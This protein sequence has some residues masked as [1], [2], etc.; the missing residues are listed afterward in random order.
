MKSKKRRAALKSRRHGF[1]RRSP[2]GTPP[3]TLVSEP[4]APPTVITWTVY[5]AESCSERRVSGLEELSPLSE[6]SGTTWIDVDGTGDAT[7]LEQ[8][9]RTLGL[10]P[11]ALE[12]VVHSHQRAKVEEYGDWLF[13]VARL[14]HLNGELETEQISMFLRRGVLVTFQPRTGDAFAPVRK[15]LRDAAS[16]LRSAGADY[17]AY[18]LLDLTVDAYYPVLENFGDRIDMIDEQ[19]ATSNP[20]SVLHAIHDLRRELLF[21]RRAVWPHRDAL[22]MLARQDRFLVHE[23]RLHL[24]DCVD[25]IT[26]IMEL[27]ETYREM[28]A[29]LRDYCMSL[30]GNRMN[31]VMK[32]LTLTATLF[33]PLSFIT[34]VY[35][36]NF[37]P[38]AS[39]WNMPELRWTFGYPF[40]WSLM[41]LVASTMIYTFYRRGWIGRRE[42]AFEPSVATGSAG[43]SAGSATSATPERAAGE[44]NATRRHDPPGADREETAR[45]EQAG[46]TVR[47]E[48]GD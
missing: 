26:A 30:V 19:A 1:R 40:A 14:P 3:G 10:H 47:G 18:S 11:L 5:D 33:I 48:R 32:W 9:G 43:G 29:D 37:D 35:G 8:I 31:E 13:I 15:R 25:H 12:D 2:P 28:C 20:R 21:L 4:S 17:L 46:G 34:G 7:V 22:Q 36:M 16:P 24:R 38:E 23:T 6:S 44:Q 45:N 42:D 27:T 39:P 41:V